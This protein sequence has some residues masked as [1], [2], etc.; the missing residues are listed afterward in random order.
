MGNQRD[1]SVAM[2]IGLDNLSLQKT[3]DDEK[4]KVHERKG[5]QKKKTSNDIFEIGGNL[6]TYPNQ[7]DLLKNNGI[8]DFRNTVGDL[9]TVRKP[10]L[11]KALGPCLF[12]MQIA[13][14]YGIG[15]GKRGKFVQYL[16]TF[17]M[18]FV[19]L[20]ILMD[21]IINIRRK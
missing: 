20:L 21:F 2:E 12:I 17:Y 14:L 5:S 13:G 3:T 11:E 7:K 6:E 15:A 10:V 16:H 9:A 4:G 8:V 18:V 19:T 1:N